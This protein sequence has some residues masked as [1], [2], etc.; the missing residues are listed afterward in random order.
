[1]SVVNAAQA[2]I[3][4]L[5]LTPHPEG[6]R[7]REVHR[8][9]ETIPAEGLPER[10]SGPRSFSTAIYYMLQGSEF[11]AW[12]RIRQ[13]EVWHFYDGAGVVLHEISPNGAY[14]ASELGRDPQRDVAPMTVIKAGWLFA[15]A[16]VERRDFA[17]V[18]CTVAPGFD[19][20]DFQM[21]TQQELLNQFPQHA[22][23]IREFSRP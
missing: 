4:K 15:A 22:K 18:G 13:D 20:A 9:S 14:R 2:W 17:L 6:G 8:C 23:I 1:M 10:F 11:S 16:L 3:D 5:Q 19:F 21:P 7:Y 12:H